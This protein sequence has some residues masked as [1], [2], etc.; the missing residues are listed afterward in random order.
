M[1]YAITEDTCFKARQLFERMIKYISH[2]IGVGDFL[3]ENQKMELAICVT[4]CYII[5]EQ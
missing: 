4:F 5:Y 2:T 3:F 1:I